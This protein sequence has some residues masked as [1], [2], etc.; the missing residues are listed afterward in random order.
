VTANL[1]EVG[2]KILVGGTRTTFEADNIG[3]VCITRQNPKQSENIISKCSRYMRGKWLDLPRETLSSIPNTYGD[4]RVE[5]KESAEAIVI[6]MPSDEGLN[7]K[8]C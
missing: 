7:I 1:K 4:I 5:Y 3:R 8:S 6:T 2:G